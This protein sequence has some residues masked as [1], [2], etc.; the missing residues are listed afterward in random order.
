MRDP[1]HP[2]LACRRAAVGAPAGTSAWEPG[3]TRH[4][5][6]NL[7]A[8]CRQLL[9]EIY[10]DEAGASMLEYVFVILLVSI[11]S[12][13]AMSIQRGRQYRYLTRFR[14][15]PAFRHRPAP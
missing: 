5:M 15:A 7:N 3:A 9:A 14:P 4:D 8:R 11:L 12:I 10:R 13:A 1:S 2:A 6:T